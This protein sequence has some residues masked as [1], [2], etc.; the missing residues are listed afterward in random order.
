MPIHMKHSYT[1][2]VHINANVLE[3]AFMEHTYVG[4]FE[5]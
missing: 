4:A 5:S 2:T 3:V 1:G